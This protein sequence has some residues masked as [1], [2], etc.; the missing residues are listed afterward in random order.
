MTTKNEIKLTKRELANIQ[1]DTDYY[2]I[3]SNNKG[4]TIGYIPVGSRI[5]KLAGKR[6]TYVIM[7]VDH[8]GKYKVYRKVHDL[9][10]AEWSLT[11][12]VLYDHWQE[13]FKLLKSSNGNKNRKVKDLK[14]KKNRKQ[15][16]NDP[17]MQIIY[18]VD[19][20][21]KDTDDDSTYNAKL[22]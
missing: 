15:R 4:Y 11:N 14:V 5:M 17:I 22:S 21:L 3:E 20:K 7:S 2:W 16:T 8:S 10:K 12:A 13:T 9:K 6:D 19:T 1:Y 18:A